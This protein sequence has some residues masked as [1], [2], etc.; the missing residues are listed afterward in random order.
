[1]T[2][3][4]DGYLSRL[5]A[6]TI[7]NASTLLGAGRERKGDPIDLAVGITLQAKVGDRVAGGEPIAVLHANDDARLQQAERVLKTAIQLSAAPVQP[8]ALIL[9]RLAV[10]TARALA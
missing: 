4:A 7:A 1:M 8:P 5:D 6:L 10:P 3:E 2:A 9:E